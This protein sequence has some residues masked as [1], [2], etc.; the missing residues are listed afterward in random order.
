MANTKGKIVGISGAM[1]S[2]EFDDKRSS[3][4]GGLCGRWRCQ[5]QGGSNPH[6]R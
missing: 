2:V 6:S 3:E 5:A 1:I 4:R